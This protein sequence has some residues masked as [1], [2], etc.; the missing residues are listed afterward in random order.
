MKSKAV[1]LIVLHFICL[2]FVFI[3][4]IE[5]IRPELE[6]SDLESRLVVEGTITDEPGP[7]KVRLTK[8]SFVYTEQD[9]IRVEP[10]SGADVHITDN[11]GNDF[12]LYQG[13]DG[14]YET[15]D[16]CLYGIP[17]NIYTLHITCEDGNQF[18]STPQLML[19]VP[20]IDSL[21]F[22]EKQRTHIEGEA[23]TTEE[24]LDILLNSSEPADKIHYLR[25]DFN[26]TWEFNMPQYIS[27]LFRGVNSTCIYRGGSASTFKVWVE[28]PQEQFH[29]YTTESSKSILV[30]STAASR[31][32]KILRFPITSIGPDDDRLSIRYSILVKQYELNKELYSYF[33]KL[34]SL[35]ETNGG[36]FDKLPSPLYG[37]IQA[38]SGNNP[39]LGYFFVSAVKTRRLFINKRETHMKTGHSEYSECGWVSPPLCSS[40]YYHYGYVSEGDPIVGV[41]VWGTD[42]YCTDCRTRGTNIK[43][44]FW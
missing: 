25:W 19:E 3:S 15:S 36:M 23:V 17:G 16:S 24:W 22:E 37:N 9:V 33:K 6:K 31:D 18:E 7:F 29:C 5:P 38:V 43:P 42:K 21:L 27:V 14:W 40:P 34:E 1:L 30:T 13:L 20:P 26:E 41:D 4:C 28:I 2:I 39:V 32:G 44:D 12:Q 35:N 11:I 8:S 10:V